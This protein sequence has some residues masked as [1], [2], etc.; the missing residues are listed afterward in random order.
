MRGYREESCYCQCPGTYGESE[1]MMRSARASQMD[2][3]HENKLL[4]EIL[5]EFEAPHKTA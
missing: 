3:Q 1:E 5:D 4:R 2:L